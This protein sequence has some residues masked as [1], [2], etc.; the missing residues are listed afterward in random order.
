MS[1]TSYPASNTTTTLIRVVKNSPEW[2]TVEEDFMKRWQKPSTT[3]LIVEDIVT[4]KC[5]DSRKKAYYEYQL[6]LLAKATGKL[7][8]RTD[9]NTMA[10]S[11]GF[12]LETELYHGTSAC[13]AK[14]VFDGL[15]LQPAASSSSTSSSSSSSLATSGESDD[16]LYHDEGGSNFLLHEYILDTCS[17]DEDESVA[18]DT[19]EMISARAQYSALTYSD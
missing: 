13:I 11:D 8:A 9:N 18:T 19:Q 4:I 16:K 1:S 10:P 5:S 6:S 3:D 14:T 17:T 15:H 7:L 12:V 2:K